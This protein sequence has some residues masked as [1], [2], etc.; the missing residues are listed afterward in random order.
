MRNWN[1]NQFR[2]SLQTQ[3]I[4]WQWW[5]RPNVVPNPPSLLKAKTTCEE[6]LQWRTEITLGFIQFNYELWRTPSFLPPQI[7]PGSVWTFPNLGANCKEQA[8]PP[9]ATSR[10]LWFNCQLWAGTWLVLCSNTFLVCDICFHMNLTGRSQR[11]EKQT[12]GS[13][14]SNFKQNWEKRQD[15]I[16]LSFKCYCSPGIDIVK[17]KI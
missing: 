4:L 5:T 8:T 7:G 15:D 6:K 17:R 16:F 12:T 2:S 11:T 9:T 14:N 13:R 10:M 3:D 1:P